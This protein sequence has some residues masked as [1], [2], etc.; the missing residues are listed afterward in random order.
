MST[1]KNINNDFIWLNEHF[2]ICKNSVCKQNTFLLVF[3]TF[4]Q[5]NLL[6]SVNISKNVIL[7]L[8]LLI[9][10]ACDLQC[11]CIEM[12]WPLFSN[13]LVRQSPTKWCI[14][15]IRAD[16]AAGQKLNHI[17]SCC[18]LTATRMHSLY[19]TKSALLLKMSVFNQIDISFD[20]HT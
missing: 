14:S 15:L 10:T 9:L 13:Y 12:T 18:D 2:L 1:F 8:F 11:T 6:K 4:F 5:L 7:L 16:K 19:F 17:F 3:F 20:R